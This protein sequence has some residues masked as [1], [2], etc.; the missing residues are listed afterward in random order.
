MSQNVTASA[1]SGIAQVQ[2]KTLPAFVS[3]DA[4][5]LDAAQSGLFTAVITLEEDD[6]SLSDALKGDLESRGFT[7][8]VSG[9]DNEILTVTW[10]N[11]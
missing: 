6:F 1:M 11:A 10:N 7:V 2:N 5:I 4:T 3:A 9:D 8:V